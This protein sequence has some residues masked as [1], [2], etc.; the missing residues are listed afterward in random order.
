MVLVVGGIASGKRS[1]ARAL[2]FSDAQMGTQL[3]DGRP[4]LCSLEELLR[5]GELDASGLADVMR[6]DVVLCCEVGMGVVPLDAD[7]RAWRERVGRSCNELAAQ[8]TRVVRM[9]CGIPVVLK[10]EES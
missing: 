6:R 4:V 9:V 2:G 8:A 5:Q 3:Y 7:Q 10:E 1:Y